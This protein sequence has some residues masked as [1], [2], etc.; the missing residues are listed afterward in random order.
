VSNNSQSTNLNRARAC[1][2]Q[3]LSWYHHT[4]IDSPEIQSALR[5]H[6]D[7]LKNSLQ[8]L[9]QEIIYIAVFGLVSRG[10]SAVL[11]ALIGEK[12]L[13]TGP[14]NG[15]TQWI[16]TVRWHPEPNL[17]IE[18]IDTPGLDEI[19]GESRAEMSRTVVR[20]AD[21]ILFVIS[22]DITRTEYQAIC[23]LSHLQKPFIL[24][25]N[26]IDL[27][28]DED[29]KSVFQKLQDLGGNTGLLSPQDIVMISAEP[30]PL[31]V[32]IELADGTINYEWETPTP[33]IDELKEKIFHL[34]RKKGRSLL[35]LN[36]L[37]Q[38]KEAEE[39]IA[40]KIINFKQKEAD[41][42][43]MEFVKYKS[44]AVGLNPIGLLDII[45]GI[46][47]DLALIR[48]LAKLYNLPMTNY[49]AGK[50]WKKILFSTGGVLLGQIISSMIL[51]IGKSTAVMTAGE[52]SSNLGIYTTTGLIQG[53]LA[54][55]GTYIVGKAAQT[56]LEQG[57]TWGELGASTLIAEMLN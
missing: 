43:I 47:T 32:R 51:G 39:N 49:Q 27:Y 7:E 20:Q 55:Y 5:P 44:V 17:K 56:Y 25:F 31:Q 14:L 22:G 26:K 46:V 10:K 30:A 36:A 16:K 15:V 34:V 53:S 52:N 1:V 57:C 28:P 37:V 4:K 29:R 12:V 3:V 21:L 48:A 2:R 13:L 50:L 42:L 8:K 6:L 35:A 24:V 33:Q 19:N 41:K 23:E 40:Q 18:L 54:G 45:G 11:N 38:A 9:E